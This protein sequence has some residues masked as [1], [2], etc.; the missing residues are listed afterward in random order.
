MEDKT[1]EL[2]TKMYSEMQSGFDRLDK[3]IEKEVA[4]LDRKIEQE[5]IK[6]ENKIV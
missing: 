5:A 3:K 2:L 1:F 6:I 4:R